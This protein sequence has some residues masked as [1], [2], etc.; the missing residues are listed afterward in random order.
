MSATELKTWMDDTGKTVI[1][2]ASVLK[3]SPSTVVRF[4]RGLPVHR[5]TQA[6]LERLVRPEGEHRASG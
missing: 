1:D 6:A 4:L 3:I 2:I 5:S